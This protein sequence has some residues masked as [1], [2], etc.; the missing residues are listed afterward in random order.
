ML[1]SHQLLVEALHR[2]CFPS[3]L[4]GWKDE[5]GSSSTPGYLGL[6]WLMI[7]AAIF[8]AISSH[9]RRGGYGRS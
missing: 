5:A 8:V 1:R 4:R 7:P 3:R 9:L 6:G 2:P